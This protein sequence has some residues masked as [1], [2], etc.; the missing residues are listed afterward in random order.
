MAT[1]ASVRS[2]RVGRHARLFR[3][4]GRGRQ[5]PPPA[6]CGPRVFDLHARARRPEPRKTSTTASSFTAAMLTRGP[7]SSGCSPPPGCARTS[8]KPTCAWSRACRWP[9]WWFERRRQEWSLEG[10][11][12]RSIRWEGG[13]GAALVGSLAAAQTP[14]A[15]SSGDIMPA[16]LHGSAR[17]PRRDRTDDVLCVPRAAGTRTPAAAGAAAH[18]RRTAVWRSTAISSPRAQRRAA[19]LQEQVAGLEGMLSGQREMP[20]RDPK[21]TPEQIR[22]MLTQQLPG[23]QREG[24][25]GE[26]RRAAAHESGKRARQRRLDRAGA[27][28]GSQSAPRRS[29]TIAPP[30]EVK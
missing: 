7:T 20:G 14:G 15:S 2:D 19:E 10:I 17:A 1:T 16:L 11:H 3:R 24:G 6:R 25:N 4:P 13:G 30:P 9:D 23:T 18:T 29:R 26:C 5:R 12:D 28:V 8:S 27:L 21:I 22:G